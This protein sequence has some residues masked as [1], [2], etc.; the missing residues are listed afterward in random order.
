[1]SYTFSFVAIILLVASG[2]DDACAWSRHVE[3]GLHVNAGRVSPTSVDSDKWLLPDTINVS[4]IVKGLF[5]FYD[6]YDQPRPG[7]PK[8]T[9]Y[10]EETTVGAGHVP[11]YIPLIFG[12]QDAVGS[13][14]AFVFT[15]SWSAQTITVRFELDTSS[16]NARMTY[17][18]DIASG[19]EISHF[20]F[21]LQGIQYSRTKLSFA[22]HD[23][24]RHLSGLDFSA[25]SGLYFAYAGESLVTLREF[26]IF[27]DTLRP[28]FSNPSSL[29]FGI[30]DPSTS[31]DTSIT[32]S[33]SDLQAVSILGYQLDDPHHA[34][35]LIDTVNHQI[36]AQDSIRIGVRYTTVGIQS[37]V[38]HLTFLTDKAAASGRMITLTGAVAYSHL[39]VPVD[40]QIATDTGKVTYLTIPINNQGT[41]MAKVD[42]VVLVGFNP[43]FVS[44]PT[45]AFLAEAGKNTD[46]KISFAPHQVGNFVDTLLIFDSGKVCASTTITG[47]ATA[48]QSSVFSASVSITSISDVVVYP[49]IADRY[50]RV[51]LAKPVDRIVVTNVI[52]ET[53]M[54]INMKGD[55]S[56]SAFIDTSLLTAGVYILRTDSAEGST[57]FVIRR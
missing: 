23:I 36:P 12:H 10:L 2:F 25:E 52:G 19:S 48:T 56:T 34:F 33:N 53:C 42:S 5:R 18:E 20:H 37:S 16:K 1:M 47:E 30:L 21:E 51:A 22:D 54:T 31:K 38:G 9:T 40:L 17:V 8:D 50:V 11:E 14:D 43:F 24:D 32:L 4:A 44:S 26:L 35:S 29:N 7:Q 27:G 55:R 57:K 28:T 49:A 6:H 41:V 46:L 39:S 45:G 15:K 3:T 13:G